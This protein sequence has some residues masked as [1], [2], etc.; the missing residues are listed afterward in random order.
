MRKTVMLLAI[1]LGLMGATACTKGQPLNWPRAVNCV[2]PP[3]D[4]SKSV[5]DVLLRD[6]MSKKMSSE[7][8]SQLGEIGAAWGTQAASCAVAWL[9]DTW[10]SPKMVSVEDAP[11]TRLTNAAAVRAQKLLADEGI[12]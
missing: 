6:G 1:S 4:L 11:Q 8:K 7:S 5:I 3:A 9:V 10:L 12:R 2:A